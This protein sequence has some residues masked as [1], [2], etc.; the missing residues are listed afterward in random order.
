MNIYDIRA[1]I[2][3]YVYAYIRNKNSQHGKAGTPY[4]IGKGCGNRAWRR[5]KGEIRRPADDIHIVILEKDLTEIGAFALERRMI[6]WHGRLDIG[7]GI[8]R[9]RTD[10]GEGSTGIK[11]TLDQIERNRLSVKATKSR[12]EQ[13]AKSSLNAKNQWK[14]PDV[15]ARTIAGARKT[16]DS[17]EYKDRHRRALLEAHR[18]RPRSRPFM[19]VET[20][21]IFTNQSEAARRFDTKRWNIGR[22]L[23]ATHL[24]FQGF[25]FR[26]LEGAVHLAPSKPIFG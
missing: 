8:L 1:S 23:T 11:R 19:C 24:N 5:N 7:T 3:F 12:P 21:E 17:P 9:N 18:A 4:Y 15:R 22:L 13:R 26:Y 14:D 16:F 20:G 25:H 10:G 2:G 6:R